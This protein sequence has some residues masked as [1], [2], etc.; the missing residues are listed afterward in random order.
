MR[1]RRLGVW[2]AVGGLIAA[3]PAFAQTEVAIGISGWTGFAPLT[4]AKEAG[5]FEK[6]GVKVEIK[7]I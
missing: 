2:V 4:L 6:N 3:Q 7:K 5:I 1:T